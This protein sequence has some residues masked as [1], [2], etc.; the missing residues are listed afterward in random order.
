MK[1]LLFIPVLLSI[2]I[3][4]NACDGD[5]KPGDLPVEIKTT[6]EKTFPAL[7]ASGGVAQTVE[8]EF[9]LEDFA[10]V[11]KYQKWIKN[12]DAP[13]NNV[14]TYIELKGIAGSDQVELKNVSVSLASAS[15][16]QFPFPS[17]TITQNEKF[18]ADRGNRVTFFQSVISEVVS[19][20]SSKVVLKYT[21]G[22]NMLNPDVKVAIK[23]YAEFYFN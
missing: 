22:T 9:R 23:I 14:D 12:A 17:S 8:V 6:A 16:N 19:K 13:M 7:I 20:G 2:A 18:T 21:P 3:L 5:K 10:G 15:G 1:K 4:F 11:S